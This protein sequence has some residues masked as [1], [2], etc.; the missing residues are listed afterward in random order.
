MALFAQQAADVDIIVTT[1]LIRE[2][3]G[4]STLADNYSRKACPQADHE[5][6]HCGHEAWVADSLTQLTHPA[7]SVVVDLAGEAGG[8]CELTKPGEKIVTPNG[9]T[10]LGYTV[11]G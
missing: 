5:G 1:A 6:A 11:G 7:G 4:T 3:D 2:V 10:I 8:N 9:V